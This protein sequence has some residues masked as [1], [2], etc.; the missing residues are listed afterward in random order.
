MRVV[1]M[2]GALKNAGDFLITKRSEELLKYCDP[3]L[4]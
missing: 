2:S 4:R 3:R 1:L